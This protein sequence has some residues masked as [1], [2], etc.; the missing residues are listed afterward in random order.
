[1]NKIVRIIVWGL[2]FLIT[3]TCGIYGFIA[4]RD[5]RGA[6]DK[7]TN[8]V[9]YFNDSVLIKNYESTDTSINAVLIDNKKINVKYINATTDTNYEYIYDDGILTTTVN[10]EDVYGK[11]T[12][13]IMLLSV[14]QNLGKTYSDINFAFDKLDLQSY[15]IDKG[16]SYTVTNNIALVKINT[17]TSLIIET[18]DDSYITQNDLLENA[19]TIKNGT[20][21]YTKSNITLNKEEVNT[22]IIS[23]MENPILTENAYNSLISVIEVL[24]EDA[25]IT[26]YF[27]EN[28]S[29]LTLGNK[30][31]NG[32]T[33]ELNPIMNEK[34]TLAFG[35]N[36]TNGFIRV[37]IE[38][39][40]IVL[41]EGSSL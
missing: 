22:P 39:D 14:A 41:N 10:I 15:T 28:Y 8:L 37:T 26:N 34:E 7:L 33:I 30:T 21:T 3:A 17:N 25:N 40:K 13:K 24:Y 36:N 31:F 16:L 1:M 27:K 18:V 19:E 35:E 6:K 9:N 38:K 11:E 2:L 4:S 20:F 32:F 23:I 5:T 29:S 12:L